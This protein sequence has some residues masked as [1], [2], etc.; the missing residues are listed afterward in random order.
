MNDIIGISGAKGS[1]KDLLASYLVEE[2]GYKRIAFADS[3]KL[4]CSQLTGLPLRYFEDPGLKEKAVHVDNEWVNFFVSGEFNSQFSKE[5]ISGINNV[6]ANQ[7]IF[8]KEWAV[9]DVFGSFQREAVRLYSE[10]NDASHKIITPRGLMKIIGTAF[11][12]DKIDDEFWVKL[13]EYRIVSS[14]NK[15]VIS[16]VR[17]INEAWM[18]KHY[19]GVICNILRDAKIY[20]SDG[21]ESEQGLPEH[22]IDYYVDN[23]GMIHD[24]YV[25]FLEKTGNSH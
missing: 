14:R 16:D 20:E 19:G 5:L 3:L 1:G 21:H 22:L 18:V 2:Y 7:S 11:F 12:R 4:I 8:N 17:W 15:V 13:L 23:N 24:M 25:D 9:I 6:V 10:W